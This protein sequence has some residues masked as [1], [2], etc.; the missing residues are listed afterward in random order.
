MLLLAT[1]GVLP[2]IKKLLLGE[3]D[4]VFLI[5]IALRSVIMFIVVVSGLRLL[6]KRGVKQ[7]SVFELVIILTLGSAAGDPMFYKDVGLL[8]CTLVFAVMLVL[9][10][11]IT[12]FVAKSKKLELLLEGK[13]IC[14]IE[15]GR[16]CIGDFKK[17]DLATDEFFSELRI[18]NVSHLG[19]VAQAFLETSGEVSVFYYEDEDVK[20][21]LPILPNEYE[22][23][24]RNITTAGK[25]ACTF[26][27]HVEELMP[28]PVH[29]CPVCKKDSWLA[30]TNRKRIG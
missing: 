12:Y 9:Y 20:Y 27:G 4:Y 11:V 17:E 5:E 26:C 24:S 29:L 8:S 23:R 22:Q 30:A 10:K 28:Q 7:L 1:D 19:Q 3:E 18:K 21:G 6:G 13:P 15:D 16:F 2:G 25:Y 14:L